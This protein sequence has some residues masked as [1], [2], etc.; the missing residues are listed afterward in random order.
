MSGVCQN[1]FYV[2]ISILLFFITGCEQSSQLDKSQDIRPVKIFTVANPVSQEFRNFPATV[3]ANADSKLA[4]RVSG[5]I[6]DFPIY[7]GN[8]VEKGQLLARLDPKDFQLQIDDRLARYELAKSQFVRAEQ[9]LKLK[10]E[11][12]S[13]F[14]QAK[15]NLSVALSS[16]NVAKTE[17][18]YTYLRAPFA[19]R[20]AN[21]A[22][23]KFEHIQAKQMILTLQSLDLI[24]ISVQVP[25][26]ITSRLKRGTGYQPTVMFDSHPGQEFLI[27]LKEW[28]TQAA[29]STLTYKVVFSLPSPPGFNVLPGMTA[30]VRVDLSQVTD[31]SQ[32]RYWLPIGAVF[33][34]EKSPVKANKRFIWLFNEDTN[35]VNK[36]EVTVGNIKNDGIEI[37]SGINTGDRVVSAGVHF[38]S[39]GLQVKAWNRESGL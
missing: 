19:G 8:H 2:T 21:L 33:I 7:A 11:P 39:E 14:D 12:Q 9:L 13:V 23:E 32:T 30:N 27:D 35:T 16:L 6:N 4:F 25:E 18:D 24:D 15:A 36:A 1:I 37:L 28:D 31:S 5:Q 3:E 26:N 38:L 22:V 10:L 29:P 20:I 34:P 17:L